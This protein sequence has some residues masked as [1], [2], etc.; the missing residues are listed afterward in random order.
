[1][2]LLYL[3]EDN[4][5]AKDELLLCSVGTSSITVIGWLTLVLWSQLNS[6]TPKS[7]KFHPFPSARSLTLPRIWNGLAVTIIGKASKLKVVA[8]NVTC[9]LIPKK[10][11][12][13]LPPSK[14]F[15]D[16][17]DLPPSLPAE[18]KPSPL[19]SLQG[20]PCP[21]SFFWG[22]LYYLADWGCFRVF[23]LPT[24]TRV[25]LDAGSHTLE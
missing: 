9:E 22:L 20:D 5:F 21:G 12:S 18:C 24:K 4:N 14:N 8:A 3:V 15:P 13:P 16:F 17:P 25:F 1:M 11:V 6:F 23:S 7:R 19:F 2:G 10:W